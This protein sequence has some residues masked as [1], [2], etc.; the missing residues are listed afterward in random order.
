MN[1]RTRRIAAWYL[2]L[3]GVL[4]S[5]WWIAMFLYPDWRRPFFAAPETEIGWVTFFL[6]DAVFFIGASMVAGI[7]LLKRWSM[8][9][10]ILLVHV[11]A[12]G[13]ATLLAIGQSLATERGWLGAEL[14]LG[15]FIVVAVIARN[16]RPQ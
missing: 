2:I 14:M 8:A 5:A 4:T 9:W 13:F 6:P 3:Q 1:E 10:P 16:L 12:V 11:G 7:G 15:H